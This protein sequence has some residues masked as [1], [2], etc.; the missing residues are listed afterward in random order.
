MA[1]ACSTDR[2]T[3]AGT[4][5][6][7]A[8]IAACAA[9]ESVLRRE[10]A[11]ELCGAGFELFFDDYRA[12]SRRDDAARELPNLLA[13][14]GAPRV[15][16]VAHTDLVRDH[17]GYAGDRG[18]VE[19]IVRRDPATCRRIVTDRTNATQV[20]G[21]DRVGV[22]IARMIALESR[23]AIAILLTTD[24]EIGLQGA[25]AVPDAWLERF[26]LFVQIDRGSRFGREL[27][28][29]IGGTR[30]CSAEREARL[31]AI[32]EALGA[33]RVPVVG[34]ST[35]VAELKAHGM[36]ADAVNL[37]CGYYAPHSADEWVDVEE[38]EEAAR[39]VRA[40]LDSEG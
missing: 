32:A 33:P 31:L 28:T 2:E 6:E 9:D 24:E 1:D 21:D 17:R 5:F 16:L 39:Y 22:A 26:E 38:A 8:L 23:R 15:C 18:R 27:V 14:R 34:G 7:R 30:L 36:R 29:Q 13:V 25:A 20:G 19:P 12:T 10:L 11:A 35:D 40:I 3:F 37:T 4:P